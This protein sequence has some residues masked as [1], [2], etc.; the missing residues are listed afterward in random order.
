MKIRLLPIATAIA[1]SASLTT[2]SIVPVTAQA[3]A[4]TMADKANPEFV[5]G[6]SFGIAGYQTF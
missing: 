5:Y 2:A 4:K 3:V 6:G 1:L